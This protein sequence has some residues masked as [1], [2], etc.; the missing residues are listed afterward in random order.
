[1]RQSARSTFSIYVRSCG[2]FHLYIKFTSR[3]AESC[4]VRH[5]SFSDWFLAMGSIQTDESHFAA[6]P[7]NYSFHG[8]LLDFDG[9]IIDSTCSAEALIL[10][11][12][13]KRMS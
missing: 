12:N 5:H 1:M 2:A 4:I 11:R 7:Q 13:A 8:I 3:A 9:T 6:P 10:Y